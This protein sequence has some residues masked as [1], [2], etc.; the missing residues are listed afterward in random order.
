MGEFQSKI[1]FVSICAK[2]C[3]NVVVDCGDV[4]NFVHVVDSVHVIDGFADVVA[5]V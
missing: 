3:H 5:F 1:I 4:A 2:N